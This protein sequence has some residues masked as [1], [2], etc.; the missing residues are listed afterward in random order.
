MT[1]YAKTMLELIETSRSHMTAEQVF[2]ALR[3][4]RSGNRPIAH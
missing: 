4:V 2:Q 1:K 3:Q